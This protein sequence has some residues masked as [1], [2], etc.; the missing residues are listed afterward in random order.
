MSSNTFSADLDPDAMLRVIVLVSG[1]A[2]GSLGVVLVVALPLHP[3]PKLLGCC[4]WL[5]FCWWEISMLARGFDD[6]GRLRMAAGGLLMYLDHKGEWR[7]ARLL[8]GSVVLQRVAWIRYRT[9][10]GLR[11]A[12]LLRGDC[13]VGNDWRRLQVIWRHVGATG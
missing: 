6:C 2:L 10:A 5:V 4:A 11:A 12:E 9:D 13:R 8:P 7:E 1:I 3:A